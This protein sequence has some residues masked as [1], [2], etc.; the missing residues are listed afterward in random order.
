LAIEL[1][2]QISEECKEVKEQPLT[3]EE[4]KKK[5]QKRLKRK[6]AQ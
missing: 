3:E 6:R 1:T 2:K 4:L 5:E